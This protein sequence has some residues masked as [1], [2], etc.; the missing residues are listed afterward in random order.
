MA[1]ISARGPAISIN[2]HGGIVALS[3]LVAL[4]C[5]L[6]PWRID[7]LWLRPDFLLLVIL[8][9]AIYQPNHIGIGTAWWL[10]LVEDLVDGAHLGQHAL[11]YVVA[12]YVLTR[13]QRRMYNF[14][15]WQ[16]AL[17]IMA[18]LIIEQ[19]V[20]IVVATFVGDSREIGLYFLSTLSGALCWFPIWLF[21]H[22]LRTRPTPRPQ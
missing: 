3:L 6:L 12:V 20:D 16:Q 5:N 17:P 4:L 19:L 1:L 15:P 18:C 11:A 2:H 9:W 7:V 10:G 21:L 14:P 22:R 8:Y 13:F